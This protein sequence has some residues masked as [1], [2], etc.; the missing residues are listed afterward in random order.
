M[1]A[2]IEALD[3]SW[4][5]HTAQRVG[6]EWLDTAPGADH[7]G[8]LRGDEDL[9]TQGLTQSLDAGDFVDRRPDHRKIEPLDGADVAVEHV[10][11]MQREVDRRNGLAGRA[12]QHIEPIETLHRFNPGIERQGT[13]LIP[14]R[15]HTKGKVASGVQTS[16]AILID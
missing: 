6:A 5:P 11:E 15:V 12:P 1:R 9:A 8:E 10:S 4:L 7:C 2:K 3:L 13:G 16:S 14:R